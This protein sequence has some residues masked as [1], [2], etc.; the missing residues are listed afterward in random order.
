M[1]NQTPVEKWE[2]DVYRQMELFAKNPSN[3]NKYY[4][5]LLAMFEKREASTR[6]QAIAKRDEE[7]R[8]ELL[9]VKVRIRN[10][11]GTSKMDDVLST[12][13]WRTNDSK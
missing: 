1:T 10:M 4:S 8:G 12:L 6:K 11:G 2:R 7:L 5:N 9:E 3:S 13:I